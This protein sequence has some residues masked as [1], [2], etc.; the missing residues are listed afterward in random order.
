MLNIKNNSTP[1]QTSIALVFLLPILL[2]LIPVPSLMLDTLILLSFLLSIYLLFHVSQNSEE[3]YSFP[4]MYL[5]LILFRLGISIGTT[6]N[7]LAS[8]S[9]PK[10]VE[11]A[12]EVIMGGNTLIGIIIFIILSIINFAVIQK[13]TDRIAGVL[14]RFNL[15]ALPGKQMSID[16]DLNQGL[17]SEK[18]AKEKRE[19][20]DRSIQL[21]GHLDGVSKF[22][23]GEAIATILMVAI[24]LIGGIIVHYQ[25]ADIGKLFFTYSKLSIGEALLTQIAMIVSAISL[26][27]MLTFKKTAQKNSSI[28]FLNITGAIFILLG[29]VPGMPNILFVAVGS[30]FWAAHIY[31]KK[32][33]PIRTTTEASLNTNVPIKEI[34]QTLEY[35][36]LDSLFEAPLILRVSKDKMHLFNQNM[37]NSVQKTAAQQYGF[38]FPKITIQEHEHSNNEVYVNGEKMTLTLELGIKKTEECLLSIYEEYGYLFVDLNSTLAWIEYVKKVKPMLFNNPLTTEQIFLIKSALVQNLKQNKHVKNI[39]GI[40]DCLNH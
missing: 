29:M 25:E 38:I 28:P 11:H 31:I 33:K 16:A 1:V 30:L 17:I 36:H 15:D 13:G 5:Y 6:R 37:L 39:E 20:L 35:S 26:S 18:E 14:A 19:R 22:A 9:H 27:L 21:A 23:K 4:V 7:I 24:S 10:L 40:W 12:G 3:F 34:P 2:F 8:S 32:E